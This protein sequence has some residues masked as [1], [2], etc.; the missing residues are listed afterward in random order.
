VVFEV[1][2]MLGRRRHGQRVLLLFDEARR[3]LVSRL[4]TGNCDDACTTV[5]YASVADLPALIDAHI[6]PA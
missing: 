1:G 2:Y 6:G 3:P 5:G 4:V